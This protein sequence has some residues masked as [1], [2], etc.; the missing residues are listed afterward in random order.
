MDVGLARAQ[1]LQRQGQ[2]PV[3]RQARA[4][5]HQHGDR[6]R[7]HQARGD[8]RPVGAGRRD[9]AAVR[10][11]LHQGARRACPRSISTRPRRC[12]TEAGYPDGFR[13]RSLPQRPLHQRRGHLPGGHCRC[14]RKIGIKVNLVAQPK[15]PH[16]TLIQ[17][18]RRRPSSICWAG[19][20]RPTTRTTSSRFLYHTRSGKD[21]SWNATRYSNPEL[22][23]KI[24]SLTGEIDAAKR[25][26][27]IAEIW[28]T[29]QRRDHLHR[30]ASPD[31]GLRHEERSRHPGVAGERGA[32]EVH[33]AEAIGID[34]RAG[35][36]R[37]QPHG[38]VSDAARHADR[39]RRR[40][41]RH[42]RRR[43][44]GR[45]RRVRAPASR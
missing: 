36:L 29:L 14:W 8:A 12:S 17:K 11:R 1:D 2:E 43:G 23:K 15:G 19:A 37:P 44:A 10:Q 25:N 20:C 38:G 7:G 30:P 3:R 33:R 6:P 31:A 34:E 27:T 40:L 22:D 45:G 9:R 5:G 42:R 39:G 32:H 16:F 24:Q 21:G 18:S 35:P 26:A 13:S 28:K 4:P 41:L